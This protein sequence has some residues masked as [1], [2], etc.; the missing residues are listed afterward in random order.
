MYYLQFIV[1][2]LFTVHCKCIICSKILDST[3]GL[4]KRQ[5]CWGS[6]EKRIKSKQS[7]QNR[8]CFLRKIFLYTSLWLQWLPNQGKKESGLAIWNF[9]HVQQPLPLPQ[10][11][12]PEFCTKWNSTPFVS[13]PGY[14]DL[15][16]PQQSCLF[17]SPGLRSNV[18]VSW[19]KQYS[20]RKDQI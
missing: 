12:G 8:C 19:K 18:N 7:G 9:S 20:F 10:T 4:W 3:S 16:F 15:I 11:C 6:C 1:S 14:F 2:V 17:R 13:V 5:F